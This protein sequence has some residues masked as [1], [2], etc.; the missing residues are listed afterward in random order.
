MRS[1][2]GLL[3]VFGLD[4]FGGGRFG[5]G[6]R[7]SPAPLGLNAYVYLIPGAPVGRPWLLTRAPLGQIVSQ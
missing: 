7:G 6:F 5:G 3:V 4:T 1:M 2:V